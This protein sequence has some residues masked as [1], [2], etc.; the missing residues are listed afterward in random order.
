MQSRYPQRTRRYALQAGAAAAG[1][2]LFAGASRPALLTPALAQDQDQDRRDDDHDDGSGHGRGRGRGGDDDNEGQVTAAQTAQIP[3]GAIEIRIVSDDAGGFVPGDLTVDMG[4][5]VAFIN[6][7]S[8]EHTATGSGFDTGIIPEGGVITVVLEE[9][10]TFRYACQIHPEMTGQIAVRDANGE[11]PPPATPAASP[12]AGAATV[13][14]A[15]LAFDPA[16][17]TV[18]TGSTVTWSNEDV[19]PH[20]ATA[21]DGQFDS[22]IFDPGASFSFTFT[23]PGTF[24]YQCL[25]HPNMQGTVV[26]EGASAAPNSPAPAANDTVTTASGAAG[27]NSAAGV[28]MIDL[29]PADTTDLGPQRVLVSLQADG[30]VRADFA[31]MGAADPARPTLSGGHGAWNETDGQLTL[32]IIVLVVDRDQRLMGT[33]VIQAEAPRPGDG[34][35]L[36]G[37]WSFT[38]SD[39][40][41]TVTSEGNGA[42]QGQAA[43]LEI[44]LPA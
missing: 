24:A 14:I 6:T 28:W 36:N 33:G 29:I 31:A 22:G 20:T 37:T 40:A 8:D 41:G 1:L 34:E 25:L 11:V 44:P 27:A 35:P 23:E 26:V 2:L 10:G 4:Q 15:N 7:H 42:W 13:R 16:T 17:I 30:L 18:P 9:A 3:P 39:P 21:V 19:T 5:T 12:V 32:E 38:M 43:P